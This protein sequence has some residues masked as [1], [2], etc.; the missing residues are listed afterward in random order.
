[1]SPIVYYALLCLAIG[2]LGRNRRGGII[3]FTLI[4]FFLHPILAL[5]L[6]FLSAP[7][8]VKEIGREKVKKR[9]ALYPG[10]RRPF[11]PT[12]PSPA[13]SEG[14]AEDEAPRAKGPRGWL[15][16]S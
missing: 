8:T 6:L 11:W 5:I 16:R 2:V 10:E 1:M 3:A 4:A 13:N 14:L 12:N 15:Q 7:R 9:R